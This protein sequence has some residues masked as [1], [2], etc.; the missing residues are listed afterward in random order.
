M[1]NRYLEALIAIK[2]LE[3]ENAE[4]NKKESQHQDSLIQQENN[5]VYCS[6]QDAVEQLVDMGFTD[7]DIVTPL[8]QKY[9]NNVDKVVHHLTPC[10]KEKV[11][12]FLK[13]LNIKEVYFDSLHDRC[14]CGR[15]S[16]AVRIPDVLDKDRIDGH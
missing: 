15:C 6:E 12:R 9:K 16:A 8:L 5:E 13:T 4:K 3:V 14:Y 11:M 2:K 7:V 1:S 10:P